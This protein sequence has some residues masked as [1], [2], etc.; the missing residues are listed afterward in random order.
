MKRKR[1]ATRESVA[2]NIKNSPDSWID[3]SDKPELSDQQLR[4]MC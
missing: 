2:M 3:V 4:R 1:K